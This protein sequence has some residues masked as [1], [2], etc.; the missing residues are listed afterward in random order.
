M[1]ELPVTAVFFDLDG[2]LVDSAPDLAGAANRMRQSRNMAP[3]PLSAYRP[4]VGSGARGMLSIAFQVTPELPEFESM[5]T[6]FLAEYAHGL[7]TST[8]LFPGVQ[9]VIEALTQ[10]QMPWGIVTNK[11]AQFA[12]PLI[13]SLPHL[14]AT[15]VLICGDTLDKAKPHPEPLWEACHR[16][17]LSS[18]ACV[19]VGDDER[20]VQAG[21]AAG[22]QTVV[23]RYGYIADHL[24]PGEWGATAHIRHPQELLSLLALDT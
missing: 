10:A 15:P 12:E 13:K 8:Q 17:N 18:D 6:E 2:T 4:H 9:Q 16:L 22:M 3:L 1:L 21:R 23:A 14:A 11:W 24:N 20:D 7:V 19:Y 5:K